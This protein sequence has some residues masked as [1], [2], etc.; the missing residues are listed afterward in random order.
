[1]FRVK[2]NI[3]YDVCFRFKNGGFMYRLKYNFSYCLIFFKCILTKKRI[4]R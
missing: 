3:V 1:M 2:M 4:T